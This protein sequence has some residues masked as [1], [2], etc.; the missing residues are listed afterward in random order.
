MRVSVIE[1]GGKRMRRWITA[2]VV[3]A[4]LAVGLGAAQA[5]TS[6]VPDGSEH[7]YVGQLLFYVPDEV[8]ARFTDPGN[9][10]NCSGTLLSPTVVLTAGHCTFGIGANG[11]STTQFGGNGR[12]GNDVWVSFAEAPNY[13]GFPA[14]AGYPPA[15][16]AK[17]YSDR[18][19]WLN[20]RS[21]GWVRGKA[22]PHPAFDSSAFEL[23]DAGIVVL[24]IP[25]NINSYGKITSLGKLDQFRT[26]PKQAQLFT[27]VGYGL[28]YIRPM[29]TVGGD[30]RNKATVM[31]TNLNGT[32]GLPDGTSATFSNNKGAGHRGGTCFGDSGGP[33]FLQ[34]TNEIV[35]IT[36]FGMSPNCTG[37]D[38]AYRID[39]ADDIKFINSFLYRLAPL[40]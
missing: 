2:I 23:A 36:S 13:D 8:D 15:A 33:V 9:W 30:S 20:E 35:A 7:P 37:V 32:F 17:R 21:H 4:V 11:S 29:G 5:I 25:V 19:A 28:S 31:L 38:S 14:S 3:F 6:P 39:Q 26:G 34:D 12:G 27:P 1:N 22:Y 40:H 18:V 24:D 16:N 10:F